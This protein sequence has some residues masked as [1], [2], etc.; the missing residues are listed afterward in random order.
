MKKILLLLLSTV[1]TSLSAQTY[2]YLGNYTSNGTPLYLENPSDVVSVETQRM[3]NN[4]LPERYPVPDYNPQYITSGYDTDVKLEKDADVW[5]TFVSEGAGYKNVLG[6]YTY[7]LNNPTNTKPS[8]EDIT[9]IFP[10]VSALGSGGGL[11]VGDKVKIG[12]FKKGTGIGWVLLANAWSSTSQSV[13]N[14]LWNLYSNPDYNPEANQSLRYHNVLLADPNNERIILGFEDIRRDYSSC[15]NDF[16]DAIFYVT[17]NPYE[18]ITTTNYAE[19]TEINNVSSAN[20]GGLESNGSLANL[21]AKRNF[22]RI[23]E[24]NNSFQKKFQ[25]KFNKTALKSKSNTVSLIDFLPETGMYK[26]EVANV[27]SPEDLLGVTNAQEIFSVDYYQGEER[28]SAVLATKT[29]GSIYD[30]S[31]VICD[32]LNSSSLEDVR[33]VE[34]RGHQIIS[35]K[36][37]R[38]SGQIEY[39]LSFSIKMDAKEDELFSFWNIDQYPSGNYQNYQIWGS[40]FSQVFSI[41]NFIIDEHTNLNGLNSTTVETV[42]PNVFV[43]SGS[44]SNGVINLNIVNRTQE[45]SVKFVGN[46]AETEV[47]NHVQVSNNFTLSG[48]YNEVLSIQTGVL[49]DIG[50]SLETAS[51]PQK[52]ALYLA[53]GPWGLDYLNDY[54]TVANFEVSTTNREYKDDFYEVDRSVSAVG[55]VKGNVNLFRHILPGDQTLNVTDYGFINFNITNNEPVEVVIMSED[56]R[57]WENRL[58]YT[59]PSNK[60]E[61]TMNLSFSDFV[62]ANGNSAEINNIKTVVFSIIGDYTNYIPFQ[63]DV[64]NLSFSKNDVLSVETFNEAINTKA[65]NYPNPFSTTTTIQLPT[66]SQTVK[67]QVYDT[68]GRVV[69]YQILNTNSSNKIQYNAP[70]LKKGMYKYRIIDDA[71]NQHSGTFII[72]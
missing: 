63:I 57:E 19:V 52:D 70:Q 64:K 31:K 66:I 2:Q 47:S 56:D 51:S 53:D 26:T 50:F 9:I 42:L 25:K 14:S 4:S 32:R 55:E 34:T 20:N 15:D 7:D 6:F 71:N 36:I 62:D 65:F 27:S 60:E 5:V 69:D 72:N 13:G 24:G 3:I 46:I 29:I 11:Q 54:V 35:S 68:I 10:N 40:S 22:K 49:F 30:H 12:T 18:A 16:N 28:V 17:A 41:A 1:I 23:K 67:I 21:I 59:I 8:K 48:D 39:T 43:K 58:R 37:K 38:A 61:R 45:T 33:T 44:Y